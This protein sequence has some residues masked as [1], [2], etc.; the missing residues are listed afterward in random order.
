MKTE[1]GWKNIIVMHKGELGKAKIPDIFPVES[2]EPPM[3]THELAKWCADWLNEHQDEKKD[4]KR[5]ISA[6]L[7]EK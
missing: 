6:E 1:M 4:L 5:L 3:T 2:T 7:M